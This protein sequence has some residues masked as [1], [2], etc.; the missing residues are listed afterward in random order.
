MRG[1]YYVKYYASI[2]Y[3]CKEVGIGFS[4][5]MNAAPALIKGPKIQLFHWKEA[6]FGNSLSSIPAPKDDILTEKTNFRLQSHNM[7]RSGRIWAITKSVVISVLTAR[8]HLS[9]VVKRD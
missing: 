2:M 4:C 7:G 1:E 6:A 3:K 9:D 5:V 8:Q